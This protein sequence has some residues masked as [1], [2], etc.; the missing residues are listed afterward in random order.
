MMFGLNDDL[1]LA[2]WI[3]GVFF[4]KSII[5]IQETVLEKKKRENKSKTG[6]IKSLLHELDFLYE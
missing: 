6:N 2:R 1:L 4:S 5:V 3:F